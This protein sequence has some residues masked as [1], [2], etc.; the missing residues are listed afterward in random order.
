MAYHGSSVRYPSSFNGLYGLRPT[1]TRVPYSGCV[2][3]TEGQ[4]SA[5]SVLGP[6]SGSISGVKTFMKAVLAQ[7]TWLLDPLCVRKK[8]DEEAYAL[9]EHGN[10]KQLCFGIIWDDGIVVPHPP[11]LRALQITKAAL[12][13]AGHKG[14]CC[15]WPW[16]WACRRRTPLQSSTG[17]PSS[18][19]NSMTSSSVFTS[20]FGYQS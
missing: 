8:W 15:P 6:I 7:Q 10:G 12:E 3:S 17:I 9:S 1:A 13:A 18:T 2:N 14:E 19:T 11:V 20:E 5:P 16:K 4:D